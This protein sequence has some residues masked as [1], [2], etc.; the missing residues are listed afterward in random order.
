MLWKLPLDLEIKTAHLHVRLLASVKVER[1]KTDRVTGL[2]GGVTEFRHKHQLLWWRTC[3][4]FCNTI[5]VIAESESEE[6]NM[7]TESLG[8]YKVMRYCVQSTFASLTTLILLNLYVTAL[9]TE[10]AQQWRRP[11]H[12]HSLP[13]SNTS[14]WTYSCQFIPTLTQAHQYQSL[15]TNNWLLSIS[16]KSNIQPQTQ[17]DWTCEGSSC[18][19]TSF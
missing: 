9:T 4:P 14:K 8:E 7:T 3:C 10:M 19:T 18:L 5:P 16:A 12:F 13:V 2:R 11:F 1:K 17:S 15:Y 6:N